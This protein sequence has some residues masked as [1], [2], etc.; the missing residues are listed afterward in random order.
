MEHR[1]RGRR[2]AFRD[3][4]GL[5]IRQ[6]G[7]AILTAAVLCAL[8]AGLLHLAV[9]HRPSTGATPAPEDAEILRFGL[10]ESKWIHQPVV[11]VRTRDGAVRQLIATPPILRHCRKGSRIRLVRTGATLR[12]DSKGCP[13]AAPLRTAGK[14]GA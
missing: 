6:Y 3:E 10:W 2:L 11:I 1:P 12:V 4:A 5:W 7:G 8:L 14:I 9:R 13:A